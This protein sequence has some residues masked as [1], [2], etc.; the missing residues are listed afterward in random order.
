MERVAGER[1]LVARRMF[2]VL[3]AVV[4]LVGVFVVGVQG[5]AQALAP[6]PPDA[7]LKQDNRALQDGRLISYCW[8]NSCVDGVPRYPSAVLVEPGTQLYIRLS[9]NRRP[10]RFSLRS[11]PSGQID[12]TL[13]RVVRDGKTV[14]WDAYFRLERPD[15]HYYLGAFGVWKGS[16]GRSG[17]AYWQ[18]HVKTGS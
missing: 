15:R 7:I 11:R 9:E 12:P 13:R 16:G 14:A 1:L 5:Q 4:G 17:D 18:F 8:S 2:F 10:E 6:R 3:V